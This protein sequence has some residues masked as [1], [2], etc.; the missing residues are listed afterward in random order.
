MKKI[1]LLLYFFSLTTT[2][3]AQLEI[4]GTVY[5]DSIP[6]ESASV[7]IKNSTK[8]VATN[9]KGEFNITVKK[10]DTLSISYL[11]L[12]NEELAIEKSSKIRFD[13]IEDNSLDEIVLLGYSY[14]R[15]SIS[16]GYI[17]EIV[18]KEEQ[19]G[20]DKP[21]L[22]PNPSSSGKFQLK[23]NE[24]YEEIKIF[25]TTINGQKIQ[26]TENRMFG[27]RLNIDLSEFATGI[28]IINI[29]ADGKSL[30]TIKAIRG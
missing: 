9:Q 8:G 14:T 15:R 16:C 11:G 5:Y 20:Q 26:Y 27:N 13:L 7:I 17:V 25:I 1:I 23:L 3:Y 22:Y 4:T 30:E 18:Y 10:G 6:L 24:A 28:Y 2:F 21:I 29:I 12:K 19:L